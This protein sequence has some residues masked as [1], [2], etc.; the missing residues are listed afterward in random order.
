M[1]GLKYSYYDKK[2][3]IFDK[4]P[5]AQWN[6][7]AEGV[8]GKSVEK[9]GDANCCTVIAL[10]CVTGN[11]YKQCYDYMRKYGRNHRD[12]MTTR[13]IERSLEGFKKFKAVKGP[14]SDSNRITLNQFIKK[15]PKGKYYVLH[16]GHAFA[17]V[18]GVVYD[19]SNK[20]RRQIT[21]AYRV[22]DLK[23]LNK[24]ENV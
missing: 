2:Y 24:E 23:S 1:S 9:M 13:D 15:H 4:N 16:R 6:P 17:I 22:Y 10:A 8:M 18:D 20:K 19:H 11:S 5:L 12:G 3:L 21:C 14:Y 7:Y